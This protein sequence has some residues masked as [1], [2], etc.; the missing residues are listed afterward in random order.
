MP[1]DGHLMNSDIEGV[2]ECTL[3][4]PMDKV[5]F[6]NQACPTPTLITTP[7]Q[8]PCTGPGEFPHPASKL[9]S[10][11]AKTPQDVHQ[12]VESS[13]IWVVKFEVTFTLSFMLLC[14]ARM[15]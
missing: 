12:N 5:P 4:R 8:P 1:D 9:P 15:F 14:S 10:S 3:S 11:S 7:P 2:R 13:C 6:T